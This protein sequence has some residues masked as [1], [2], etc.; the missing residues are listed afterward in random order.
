MA[1]SFANEAQTT[2]DGAINASTTSITVISYAD[3]PVSGDFR[4]RVDDEFMLVT[5]GH[6]TNTWTVT[7]ECEDSSR[8]PAASHSSGATVTQVLTAGALGAIRFDPRSRSVIF[9]ECFSDAVVSDGLVTGPRPGS[10]CRTVASGTNARILTQ[11][12]SVGGSAPRPGLFALVTGTDAGGRVALF[13]SSS[14]ASDAVQIDAAVDVEFGAVLFIGLIPTS[15]V[16]VYRAGLGDSVTGEP[17]DGVY[18]R[19]KQDVNSG[20]WEAVC[21]ANNSESTLDTGLSPSAFD[22]HTMGFRITGTSSVEFFIDGVS[23]GT[24]STNIPNGSS[25]RMGLMPVSI[26]KSSG[27]NDWDVGLDAYWYVFDFTSQR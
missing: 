1:D 12:A 16:V 20:K 19:Y 18:F 27:A 2:L 10:G 9:D 3:F 7:R 24:I 17:V 23:I 5:A 22:Y 8:F 21:R 26:V 6:G 4:I 11:A 13:G 15:G 25:R 14:V